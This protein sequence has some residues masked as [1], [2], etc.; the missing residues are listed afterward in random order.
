[1]RVLGV[2]GYARGWVAVALEDG[3]F[4]GVELSRRFDELAAA[5]AAAIGVDIPIGLPELPPRPADV[6]AR[7]F[8]APLGSTVFPAPPRAVAEAP[9]Y[10]AANALMRELTGGGISR[11][12]F[13]LSARILEVAAVAERDERVVEVHPEAS[14]RELAGEP[15]RASKHSW[16][17]FQLRRR[18]LAAAGI[19]IPDDLPHAPLADTLDAAAAAWSADRYARDAAVPLPA[20]HTARIGAIWR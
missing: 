17:G 2:D 4:A 20:G 11:Q 9:D 5:G 6:A 10:A 3:R 15:V 18:L 16:S 13:A 7:S 19:E 14:F 8:V 1:M 12:A